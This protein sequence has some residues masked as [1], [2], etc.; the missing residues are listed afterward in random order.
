[1][2]DNQKVLDGER[3]QVERDR[4]VEDR[5]N[6]VLTARRL[7]DKNAAFE[8]SKLPARTDVGSGEMQ[9]NI[10]S[11]TTINYPPPEPPLKPDTP[12]AEVAIEPKPESEA[13]KPE[14]P[15]SAEPEPPPK[16]DPPPIEVIKPHQMTVEK[17]SM[18]NLAKTILKYAAIFGV[19]GSIGLLASWAITKPDPPAVAAPIPP[20]M[21]ATQRPDEIEVWRPGE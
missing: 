1:M 13:S 7:G 12:P 16:P 4:D 18:G 8:A 19:G 3:G 6:E 10:D 14:P 21:N 15:A 2:V 17:K 11:P 9:I 20:T 5:I